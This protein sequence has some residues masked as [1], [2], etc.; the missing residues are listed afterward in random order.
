MYYGLYF[1]SSLV[2]MMSFKYDNSNTNQYEMN[3]YCTQINTTVIGGASKLFQAFVKDKQNISISAKINRAKFT[4]DMLSKLGF[5]CVGYESPNFNWVNVRS[6][7]EYSK[8]MSNNKKTKNLMI[9]DFADY[10]NTSA[11]K[12][13][14]KNGY[15]KVY[16]CGESIWKYQQ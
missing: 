12:I 5:V 8:Y 9:D 1:E 13:M 10:Q 14:M 3:A 2:A 11:D 15:V 4:G 7:I 16:D 6:D